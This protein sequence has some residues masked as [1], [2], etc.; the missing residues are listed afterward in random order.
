MPLDLAGK[1]LDCLLEVRVRFGIAQLLDLGDEL[2]AFQA[3]SGQF[4]L[5]EL[6]VSCNEIVEFTLFLA[7]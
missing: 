6:L 5:V 1:L 2:L 3:K 4:F 7:L